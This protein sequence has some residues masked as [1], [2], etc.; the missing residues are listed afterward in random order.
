VGGV[1]GGAAHTTHKNPFP[2]LK[3]NLI[4]DF[5]RLLQEAIHWR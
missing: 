2:E 1:G 3:V 4:D 5:S